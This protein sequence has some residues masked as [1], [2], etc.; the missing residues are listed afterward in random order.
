MGAAAIFKE[1]AALEACE[2]Y[3]GIGAGKEVRPAC[4]SARLI[5]DR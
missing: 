5:M 1:Y 2:N 4:E 3:L